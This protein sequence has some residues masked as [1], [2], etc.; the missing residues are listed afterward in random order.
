VLLSLAHSL[1]FKDVHTLASERLA[2]E[3]LQE[4]IN[5]NEKAAVINNKVKRNFAFI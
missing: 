3:T 4:A 2:V 5:V 1:P